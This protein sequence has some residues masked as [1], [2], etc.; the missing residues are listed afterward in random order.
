MAQHVTIR[1]LCSLSPTTPAGRR[2]E[3][4]N[5]VTPVVPPDYPRRLAQ[6]QPQTRLRVAIA[7]IVVPVH[8]CIR[9]VHTG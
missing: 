9:L 8:S 5:A 3:Q 1:P 7:Q 4:V 6:L 2:Q